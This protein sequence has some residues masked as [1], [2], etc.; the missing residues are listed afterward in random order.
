MILPWQQ[1]QWQRMTQASNLGRLPHALLLSGPD[2]VGKFR[3]A[4]SLAKSLLCHNPDAEVEACGKCESCLLFRAGN[5][6][7]LYLIQPDAESKSNEIKVDMI[8]ELVEQLSLSSRSGGRKV[9]IIRPADRMNTST[10][11]ALLKTL[12]EPPGNSILML[13]SAL[14]AR[15]P[16]TI[17]S[18]CQHVHFPMPPTGMV[19]PWLREQLKLDD[20]AERLLH[21]SGGAPFGALA[22]DEAGELEQIDM[23]TRELLSLSSGQIDPVKIAERWSKLDLSHTLRWMMCSLIDILR[24]QVS[25]QPPIIFNEDKHETLRYLAKRLNSASVQRVL[26]KVYEARRLVDSNL[27]PQLMLES[28]LIE[29]DTCLRQAARI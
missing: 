13:L 23:L 1:A 26:A 6:L 5:H 19:L 10:A 25:P 12:E 21:L 18:R 11:N 16:A 15:L 28:L 17:L 20:Q 27:N 24:L 9:V 7:D 29:W 3:F 4:Q 8:R 2:G 22:L 14:P